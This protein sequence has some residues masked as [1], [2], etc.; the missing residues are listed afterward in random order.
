MT[1]LLKDKDVTSLF[2][3]DMALD[4]M[5]ELFRQ[6]GDGN[7]IVRQRTRM[8]LPDGS[9]NLMAGWVGEPINAYGLKMYGGAGRDAGTTAQPLVLLY[10]GTTGALL[11]IL[12]A[13][14]LGAVRTGAVS[15]IATRYMARKDASTV[16]MIGVGG[17]AATQLEAVCKVRDIRQALVYS[18][19]EVK[20]EAFAREMS[21][22][23]GIPVTAAESAEACI[24][25]AD[26]AITITNAATPV[27]K[28]A[29][30]KPGTHVNAAGSNNMLHAEVD[31]ETITRASM[32]ATDDV[33]QAKTESGE[34]I[35]AI[36]QGLARWEQIH[37]LADVVSGRVSG[38]PSANA[39]TLFAS[40]GI[41]TEDVAAAR[42]IYEAARE[43]GIGTEIPL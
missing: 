43:R 28:G 26:I 25:D 8:A 38:R 32:I 24:R 12:E 3:M 15:G 34:L 11:A 10:D 29:W 20:R 19:T 7:A 39:I 2:T 16:G 31:G 36:T 21:Q 22:E 40:Q 5:E 27:L 42:V 18:R 37:E 14:Q 9:N 13:A 17:Q 33:A 1:L 30:L 6:R 4:A 35:S 23:L 41:G